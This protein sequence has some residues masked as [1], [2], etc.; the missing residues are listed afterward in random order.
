MTSWALLSG[1]YS[2]GTIQSTKRGKLIRIFVILFLIYY[3][4]KLITAMM[5]NDDS[6]W[7]YYLGDYSAVLMTMCP[8]IYFETLVLSINTKSVLTL[9]YYYKSE[10]SGKLSWLGTTQLIKGNQSSD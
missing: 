1:K 2:D 6:V 5:L 4:I 9:F 3:G 10:K 8:R 7:I